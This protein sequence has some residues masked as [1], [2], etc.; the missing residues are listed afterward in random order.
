MFKDI[1]LFGISLSVSEFCK[2]ILW[3]TNHTNTKYLQRK[4]F[5][6]V[7]CQIRGTGPYIFSGLDELPLKI[8]MP[9]AWEASHIF[10]CVITNANS[11]QQFNAI[12]MLHY[13]FVWFYSSMHGASKIISVSDGVIR[14][15]NDAYRAAGIRCFYTSK[16]LWSTHQ[17]GAWKLEFSADAVRHD[18]NNHTSIWT[19]I[20]FWKTIKI[21]T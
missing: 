7:Y 10:N 6:C 13:N 20:R 15:A 2:Y 19:K 17:N 4:I 21:L 5:I 18:V 16:I 9:A 11:R 8:I 1:F 14:Q 12:V 3:Y